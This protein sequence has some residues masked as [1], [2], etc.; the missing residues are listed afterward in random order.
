MSDE[1]CLYCR[2]DAEWEIVTTDGSPLC[3]SCNDVSHIGNAVREYFEGGVVVF[4]VK[5]STHGEA[6][7]CNENRA[8]VEAQLLRGLN[9]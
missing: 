1:T 2:D 6:E 5:T 4:R 8:K 9:E 7:L 3:F